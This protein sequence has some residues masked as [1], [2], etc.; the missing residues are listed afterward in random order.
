MQKYF[1]DKIPEAL[2]LKQSDKTTKLKAKQWFPHGYNLP[3]NY[4]KIRDS[5]PGKEDYY[6]GSFLKAKREKFD[7]FYEQHKDEPFDLSS[8]SVV[9]CFNDVD[10]VDAAVDFTDEFFANETK[11][12]VYV[13]ND[14]GKYV[15]NEDGSMKTEDIFDQ[16][17]LHSA[18]L[19]TACNR[20]YRMNFLKRKT[21]PIIP[22][23]G[24]DK[25]G[26]QSVIA[27]KYLRYKKKL[28]SKIF[29]RYYFEKEGYDFKD[30]FFIDSPNCEKEMPELDFCGKKHKKCKVDGFIPLHIRQQ[31]EPEATKPLVIEFNGC[32]W[33]GCEKCFK[34]DDQKVGNRTILHRRWETIERQRAIENLGYEVKV[35]WGHD[36]EKMLNDRTSDVYKEHN[37]EDGELKHD[38]LKRKFD[39]MDDIS[40]IDPRNAFFGG[41]IYD[42][43]SQL[44]DFFRPDW[45]GKEKT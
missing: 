36:V 20:L 18:T 21:I 41:M 43:F 40:P 5:L 26:N 38:L 17:F 6:Y 13:K 11:R 19:T 37:K 4:G 9:Y 25:K 28:I 14:E 31:K 29:C 16:V 45:T 1:L 7:E 35:I 3:E 22:E 39:M 42:K 27:S 2:D 34:N 23:G 30:I 33:H 12:T 15:T 24:Y 10:I 8:E 32:A 44:F